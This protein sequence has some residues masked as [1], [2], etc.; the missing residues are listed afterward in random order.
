[1]GAAAESASWS[2]R[3]GQELALQTLDARSRVAENSNRWPSD[4]VLAE[5]ATHGGEE[6]QI[7]HVVGLVEHRHLD[8]GE[9]AVALPDQV[10]ETAGAGHDDVDA[11]TQGA[12]LWVL[13]DA[14]E[15]RCG[16]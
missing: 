8:V 2:H 3:V 11:P 6:P 10:L 15:D 16:R 5:Q 13:T 14:A 1:M 9:A 12:D 4:G 7:G